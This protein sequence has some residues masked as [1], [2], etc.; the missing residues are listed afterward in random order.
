MGILL[1]SVEKLSPEVLQYFRQGRGFHLVGRFF[2]S[3]NK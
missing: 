2:I 1:G 3:E